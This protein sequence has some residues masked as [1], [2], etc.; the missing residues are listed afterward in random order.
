MSRSVGEFHT[1]WQRSVAFGPCVFENEGEACDW[2]FYR[3]AYGV[4]ARL[5]I[6]TFVHVYSVAAS[7][8][9]VGA[10][11]GCAAPCAQEDF[12]CAYKHGA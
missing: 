1:L 7:S 8:E 12:L 6:V 11:G 4:C 9:G 3:D 2:Q 10:I 5:I